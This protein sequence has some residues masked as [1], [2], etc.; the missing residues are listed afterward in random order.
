[1]RLSLVLVLIL[2]ILSA[3]IPQT[4]AL[5]NPAA[6]YCIEMG[7]DYGNGYCILP[8]G[9]Q[10][11]EWDFLL[12]RTGQ[13]YSYCSEQG[14]ELKVTKS[15]DK[16]LIFLL[17]ECAVCVLEDGSEVEVTQLMGLDF[18]ES[19][20]GD[21]TCGLPE[22]AETCPEDCPTSGTDGLC[23]PLSEGK[24]DI[25]CPRGKDPDCKYKDDLDE[26]K[27]IHPE[28]ETKK[29]EHIT[30][31]SGRMTIG[32]TIQIP[33]LMMTQQDIGSMDLE[34]SYDPK[35]LKVEDVIDGSLV[36]NSLVE[37]NIE[38]DGL[39]YVAVVDTNGFKG[40]GS[41][42]HIKFS[43]VAPEGRSELNIEDSS[44]TD[45]DGNPISLSTYDGEFLVVNLEAMKGDCNGDGKI[46]SID[47]L[48]AI[49]M[50]VK[51]IE[52]DLIADMDDDGKITAT[53]SL[54]ILKRSVRKME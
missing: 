14:Y 47:A 18:R 41:I 52:P 45:P 46:N 24:C 33:I 12:G 22:N 35:I 3:I 5:I 30:F 20:C 1:M 2:S 25:D 39:I 44:I 34:L 28:T 48:I 10:V 32:G 43:V 16:C 38:R 50:S 19:H 27:E 21:G 6:S 17:D 4:N 49:K 8:D 29:Q 23:E 7:Y 42:V 40:E 36:K 13:E 53:D 11:E 15:G 31:M 37:S 51:I 54:E 9:R 26:E